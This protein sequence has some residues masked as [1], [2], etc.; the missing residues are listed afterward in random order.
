[1][2]Y[3]IKSLTLYVYEIFSIPLEPQKLKNYFCCALPFEIE[4]S[5]QFPGSL[6]PLNPHEEAQSRLKNLFKD[7]PTN[8][9]PDG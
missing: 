9:N 1:M 5:L 3:I 4:Y 7:M 8:T 6:V 2:A